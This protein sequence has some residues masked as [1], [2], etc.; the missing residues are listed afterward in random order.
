[1][2]KG[3]VQLWGNMRFCLACGMSA[4]EAMNSNTPICPAPLDKWIDAKAEVLQDSTTAQFDSLRA[5]INYN[6]DQAQED[7]LV[8]YLFIEPTEPYPEHTPIGICA[9][10]GDPGY[11]MIDATIFCWAD[12]YNRA[13]WPERDRYRGLEPVVIEVPTVI[14][15]EDLEMLRAWWQRMIRG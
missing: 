7:L 5:L 14:K 2:I 9:D 15:W 13:N 3:H 6:L 8:N 1:M 12:A 4:E 11:V 10:C